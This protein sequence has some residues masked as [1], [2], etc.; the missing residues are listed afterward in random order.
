MENILIIYGIP[1]DIVNATM[2]LNRNTSAM[3]RSPDGYTPYFE[4]KT[5]VLQGDT[6][7][8]YEIS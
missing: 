2:M 6:L 7:D 3:V 8:I 5:G 1:K 4:I